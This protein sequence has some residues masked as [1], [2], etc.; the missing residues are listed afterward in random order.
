M[1]TN[2]D[3]LT[4]MAELQDKAGELLGYWEIHKDTPAAQRFAVEDLLGILRFIAE[5]E[6]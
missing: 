6:D 4:A 5:L 2:E 1:L 3:K